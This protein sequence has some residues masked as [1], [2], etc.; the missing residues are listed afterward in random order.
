MTT[1][2]NPARTAELLEILDMASESPWQ[3]E[4][5]WAMPSGGVMYSLIP[6]RLS[7]ACKNGDDAHAIATLP[8]LATELRA[9]L[10]EIERLREL[11]LKREAS[12]HAPRRGSAFTGRRTARN[13]PSIPT[14]AGAGRVSMTAEPEFT[15]TA[16]A[17]LLW[18][19]WHHQGSSSPVG[20][21]IR[22]ALGMDRSE[23]LSAERVAEAKRYGELM[24][25]KPGDCRELP[26]DRNP[27]APWLTDA[28]HLCTEN[29]CE[30]GHISAR[31]RELSAK[32]KND[33]D[34]LAAA[35]AQLSERQGDALPPIERDESMDRTYI[36]LPGG[37]EI[38][39]KGKGS[40]FRIC[41][42]KKHERWPVL[43]EHLHAPL[44]ALARDVRAA[45]P[46]AQVPDGI[47]EVQPSFDYKG[48]GIFQPK[49]TVYF[50]PVKDAG[51]HPV[52]KERDKLVAMLAAAP[53]PDA[54]RAMAKGE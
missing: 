29:G 49:V 8:D 17:A 32:I 6:G 31:L 45:Q 38:Q 52:W 48:S 25:H 28:H 50:T 21:P 20:Q 42:T 41:D 4:R 39:T 35:Q 15:D 9:A 27:N 44:E 2:Y 5:I 19:L 10:A 46:A 51:N 16:R 47:D 1:Q 18:V 30:Q 33:R 36:P 7:V 37:W 34:A 14:D 13:D 3:A 53:K 22:F 43:D 23:P 40:T 11:M 54:I 12:E 24:G 26:D